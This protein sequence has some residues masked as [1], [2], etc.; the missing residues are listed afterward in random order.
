MRLRVLILEGSSFP[1]SEVERIELSSMYGIMGRAA[2]F[3]MGLE[4]L[5]IKFYLAPKDGATLKWWVPHEQRP[6]YFSKEEIIEEMEWLFKAVVSGVTGFGA[7]GAGPNEARR[8]YYDT[9]ADHMTLKSWRG[10]LGKVLRRLGFVGR[11]GVI[12]IRRTKDLEEIW[13]METQYAQAF[14]KILGSPKEGHNKRRGRELRLQLWHRDSENNDDMR[15]VKEVL[16]PIMVRNS[17]KWRR[18]IGSRVGR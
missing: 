15:L 14:S 11:W 13:D 8:K 16:A 17:T 4:T 5:A 18:N 7:L 10:K 12:E 1:T 6:A 2:R 9:W 3:M